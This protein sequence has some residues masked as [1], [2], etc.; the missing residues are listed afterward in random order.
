MQI[1]LAP[2][3]FKRSLSAIEACTAIEQ[4]LRDG[5][6]HSLPLPDFIHHPIADGGEGTME[7]VVTAL[8]GRWIYLETRD[9][10]GRPIQTRYGW[11]DKLPARPQE[12]PNP[13][14]ALTAP[15]AV[16]EMSAASG[17]DLVSDLP[18]DPWQASTF[19]TGHMLRHAVEQGA[20]SIFLGIGG[21]ATNDAGCGMAAALGYQWIDAADKP[22]PSSRLPARLTEAK[23]IDATQAVHLPPL[24]VAVDVTNP[25]LGDDGATRIYGPQKGI[26]ATDFER[27][28][29]R[30][31]HLAHL[32]RKLRPE[33]PTDAIDQP[34]GGAAGGLGFTLRN[35]LGAKLLPGFDLIAALTSIEQAISTADLV[36]T[37]EG[38]FDHQSLN[39]KGPAGVARMARRLGKPAIVMCGLLDHAAASEAGFAAAWQAK[40]DHMTTSEAIAGAAGLLR[41]CARQ[42]SPLLQTIIGVR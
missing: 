33:I 5:W 20:G 29:A 31:A 39:G 6:P 16:I 42:N 21:S 30:I 14:M 12:S 25:L 3:K 18:P 38:R 24:L 15:V 41:E 7:A 17:L 10:H 37:G 23:S 28:E 27:H 1:L 36:I 22:I 19:G 11:I 8:G 4:G 26:A 2:D 9:A 13:D 35:L 40:P 32:V 34:G